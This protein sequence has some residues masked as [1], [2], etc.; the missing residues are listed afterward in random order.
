[1]KFDYISGSD[2]INL[3]PEQIENITG[4]NSKI[5]FL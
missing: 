1:M 5:M 3:S 4:K 2:S